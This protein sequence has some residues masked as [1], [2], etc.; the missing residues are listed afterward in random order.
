MNFVG[1]HVMRKES[2]ENEDVAA[3]LNE[4][5]IPVLV[6]K[7]ERSDLDRIYTSFISA[8]SKSAGHP[9]N[10]ILTPELKP[11]FG[12]TYFPGPDTLPENSDQV[13]ILQ[14]LKK[15]KDAWATQEIRSRA[16]ADDS[17]EKT[18]KWSAD[19]THSS[20]ED[21]GRLD[22]E[23]LESSMNYFYDT[24]D[25]EN[26]GFG[27][28][29]YNDQDGKAIG[30]D[31]TLPKFLTP[32]KLA[33]LLRL[34]Q[35][36][37]PVI[38]V[39]GKNDA[40][41]GMNM[42]FTGLKNM[43]LGGIRDHIGHGFF[44]SSV[45]INWSLPSFEKTLSDNAQLLHVYLDAFLVSYP[46]MYHANPIFLGAVYD[47]AKY[48]MTTLAH[49]A[50]GFYSGEAAD[51]LYRKGDSEKREGAYYVWTQKE[52]ESVVG[53]VAGPILSTFFNV[54]E[55][56]NV[57]KAHDIHDEF[58]NQNVLARAIHSQVLAKQLGMEE[59]E[60]QRIIEEGQNALRAHREKERVRPAIDDKIITSWNGIAIGALSRT[61]AVLSMVDSEFSA[62]CLQAAI[63]AA[64]F[65]EQ[66]LYDS[67]TKTLYRM[68]REG[69]S[70]VKAFAEDYAF[71]IEGLIDLY[72]ATF[73]EKWLRWADDLQR[74]LVKKLM[75]E[76]LTPRR[77]PTRSLLRH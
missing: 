76:I 65:I 18:R 31:E 69:R 15:V 64:E 8:T 57:G 74:E 5:Y 4:A 40:N 73:S 77:N 17:L 7:D 1:S 16:D 27:T 51:S 19:G 46:L 41:N 58:L 33:A 39:V 54:K 25:S 50:G 14:I 6:D 52:F 30:I 60:V 10:V 38:D 24:Y 70:E 63:K 32:F 42:A 36:P 22:I 34:V 28:P 66:E 67:S 21:D 68:W 13:D 72:E 62:K 61:G 47:I 20:P 23:L 2:F 11:F 49:S 55:D 44:R 43:A 29:V 26:G 45:T 53:S 9:L 71:L 75:I 35:Y 3:V 12:G 37:K 56:G 59:S 48:L